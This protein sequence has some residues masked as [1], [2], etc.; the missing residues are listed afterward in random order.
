MNNLFISENDVR[1][2]TK[3]KFYPDG[4]QKL[5]VFDKPVY[6]KP[7]FELHEYKDRDRPAKYNTDGESRIDNLCRTKNKVFD[8]A[9]M[10][11]WQYFVTGTFRPDDKAISRRRFHSR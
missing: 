6:I 1:F 9:F 5:T 7:G 3:V 11:E 8:I 2:N 10:N 4:S